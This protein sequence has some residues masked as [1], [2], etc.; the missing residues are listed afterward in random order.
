MKTVLTLQIPWKDS[1]DRQMSLAHSLRTTAVGCGPYSIFAVSQL[2][3]LGVVEALY[4]GLAEHLRPLVLLDLWYFDSQPDGSSTLII[5]EQPVY[6]QPGS[7]PRTHGDPWC[8][9]LSVTP[10][11]LGPCKF[12]FFFLLPQTLSASLSSVGPPFLTLTPVFHPLVRK[13]S[14]GWVGVIVELT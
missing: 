3:A 7:W 14:P 1:W 8:P 9:P 2:N 13:C 10:S 4:S 12:Q 11:S 6:A 5:L